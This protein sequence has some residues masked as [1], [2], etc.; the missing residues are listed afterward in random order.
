M[1]RTPNRSD[2]GDQAGSNG[3]T[4]QGSTTENLH[5]FTEEIRSRAC[6]D[7]DPSEIAAIGEKYH[8]SPDQARRYWATLRLMDRALKPL[9]RC[10]PG[11]GAPSLPRLPE[12]YEIL[13]EIGRGGMGVVYRARQKSLGR[14]VAVKVLHAAGGPSGRARERFLREARS[15][16]RL[17]H[18]GIVS[19]HEVGEYE[20]RIFFSMDL[21]EGE[22]LDEMIRRGPLPAKVAAGIL[23]Q[24]GAAV[25]YI[26]TNG[27][28]HRDLKPENVLMD[29][30][31]NAVLA[32]F[33]LAC[34]SQSGDSS[35]SRL[36]RSGQLV[37]TPVYMSPEQA[38]GETNQIG[39]T[40]DIYALG[41]I[42][43]E[44]LTGRAPFEGD[45]IAETVYAV[46]HTEPR[47]PREIHPSIPADIE[48]VCLKAMARHPGARYPS[49]RSMSEDLE[50]FERGDSVRARK[51][52]ATSLAWRFGCRNR[53]RL[54][55]S[56]AVG[57]FA[58]VLGILFTPPG[59]PREEVP[60]AQ[61]PPGAPHRLTL[62]QDRIPVMVDEYENELWKEETLPTM[63]DLVHHRD[64]LV[65]LVREARDGSPAEAVLL[66]AAT[67]DLRRG[68]GRITFDE[69]SP[70]H[71]D[72]TWAWG[73]GSAWLGRLFPDGELVA[74]I[75]WIQHGEGAAA[76]VCFY[77]TETGQELYRF[78]S[79]GHLKALILEQPDDARGSL[80]VCT[81]VSNAFVTRNVKN[82]FTPILLEI[83]AADLPE[84]GSRAAVPPVPD[85]A[86]L[87]SLPLACGLLFP[88]SIWEPYEEGSGRRGIH[89]RQI[90][91][92]SRTDPLELYC[93]LLDDRLYRIDPDGTVLSA[94]F[95]GD[96]LSRVSE[97][98]EQLG[99]PVRPP[100]PIPFLGTGE[101]NLGHI[102]GNF[103]GSGSH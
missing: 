78:W 44:C 93:L 65:L 42:L 61:L 95:V 96:T 6:A 29:P 51:V 16:A 12:D 82:L 72:E 79:Y 23:G 91:L 52:S 7:A 1:R 46:I 57:L 24:L 48:A 17:H 60:G 89:H 63:Q 3:K 59:D 103:Q 31:G 70:Y 99:R 62:I 4:H 36:T 90:A 26:H 9:L 27:I 74:C 53:R 37:G 94:S 43:Y 45:S 10:Y 32:D 75:C 5:L 66:D 47:R 40:S 49:A 84:P 39:E 102:P 15:L 71:P 14:A 80:I 33:G 56:A 54:C 35:R 41:A 13:E 97:D 83:W 8:L 58:F 30:E 28:L 21:V 88:E 92:N 69:R 22:P 68:F 67:G 73:A 100:D 34:D 81:G 38:R 76:A 87:V 64:D 19:I 55:V 25:E 20:G 85:G 18:P 98:A 86:G 101:E 2:L 50:R 77:S 11:L